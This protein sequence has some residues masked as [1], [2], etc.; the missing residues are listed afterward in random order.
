MQQGMIHFLLKDDHR[1][2]NLF[3]AWS[4]KSKLN[5]SHHDPQS[6]GR[7]VWQRRICAKYFSIGRTSHAI[8]YSWEC[9]SQQEEMHGSAYLSYPLK[10][11]CP[12]TECFARQC[13]DPF[14]SVTHKVWNWNA[15]MSHLTLCNFTS[16][17]EGCRIG[18]SGLWYLLEDALDD[19]QKSLEQF[20]N[21][22]K[23]VQQ[24][25]DNISKDFL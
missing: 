18:S 16:A 8:N 13:P 11:R 14:A 5:L 3:P 10:R 25:K 1:W 17:D 15:F 2:W 6:P 12:Q 4:P 21:A 20:I 7:T 19:F 9:C 22:G 23:S 24:L